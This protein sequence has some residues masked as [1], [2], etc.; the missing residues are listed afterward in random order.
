VRKLIL[1]DLL[2]YDIGDVIELKKPHPCG[3]K[4]WKILKV[5]VDYRLECEGCGHIVLIP[6]IKL[7][8]MIKNK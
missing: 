1:A 6:R 5:G 8:K 2:K 3:S 4:M 7:Y